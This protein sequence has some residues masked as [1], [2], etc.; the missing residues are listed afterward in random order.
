M[1]ASD[2]EHARVVAK[3]LGE[4]AGEKP[5]IVLH[6]ESGAHER[7]RR[8]AKGKSRWIVAV[9]MV[10]EGVDIPRLRVGVYATTAKTAMIFRQIVGRFVRVG[11]GAGSGDQ[12]WLFMP[13]EGVLRT[14]ADKIEDEIQ[15][16]ARKGPGED[17]W[18]E[19]PDR[20]E[21]E[22]ADSEADF[23]PVAADVVPQ[24]NLFGEAGGEDVQPTAAPAPVV[25]PNPDEV[26]EEPR[27]RPRLP[28]PP[29]PARASDTA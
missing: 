12:S 20:V 1:I 21:T 3:A 26:E 11:S 15:R 8:F 19:P 5:T 22:R 2:S 24:M 23:V 13:G 25:A 14:H 7:L 9:N 29:R 6:A 17:E 4:I 10:S 16:V 27:G 18:D 28:A